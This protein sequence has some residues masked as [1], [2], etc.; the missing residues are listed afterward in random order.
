MSRT[1]GE[2]GMMSIPCSA[3]TDMWRMPMMK[4]LGLSGLPVFQAGQA[5][6]Q[7]PH[8]V[9]VKPSSRSFQPRS[10][11]V[12]SPN[13]ASSSSRSSAGS[14]PRGAS[15]RKQMFGKAVAMWRCLLNGR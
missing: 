14:S 12:R 7:R 6:W 9:Q 8:S 1:I 5:S 15:L 2:F 10:W 3:S 11:S 4:C 13:D